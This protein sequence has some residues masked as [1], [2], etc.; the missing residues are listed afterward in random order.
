[1]LCNNIK[2]FILALPL[3]IIFIILLMDFV[4]LL[5]TWQ[6]RIF[7]GRFPNKDHWG[8]K[9]FRVGLKWINK[10]PKIKVTDNTRLVVIDMIRGNYCRS[11]IQHWQ[12]ASL[13]LGIGEYLKTK[14]D[15]KAQKRVI[16]FL[17]SRFNQSGNWEVKPKEIDVAILAYAVMK[18]DSLVI[19]KYR[20]A[21]DEVWNLIKNHIG[22]DKTVFYRNC[23]KNYRYVDTIGMICPFLVNY[24]LRFN[25]QDSI[26]L[27][28]KQIS[29]FNQYGMLQNQNIPFHG[30]KVDDK[31]TMGSSGWGR[32]LAWYAIGLID[33]WRDLPNADSRKVILLESIIKLVRI[34]IRFQNKNG[35]WNWTITREEANPD[36]STTAALAWF[37]MVAA[38]IPEIK[39]QCLESYKKAMQYLM[40]VTRRTGEVDFSQGDTKDFGIYSQL[41]DIL[42][43][44]QGF[45][46]RC[47]NKV[48]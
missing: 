9:V 25:C 4:P 17:N 46:M 33:S 11:A 44:T 32:G 36:S 43:F 48:P 7:I 3:L 39:S 45:V 27:A 14:K 37:L 31:V 21:F 10:T 24:G 28:I 13:L 38:E 6:S 35:C 1:M 26:N 47:L 40:S 2:V 20:P 22:E 23:V 30:Y 29:E 12:E 5:N 16:R 41:F 8:S 42:P 18:L 19:D 15:K 34:I